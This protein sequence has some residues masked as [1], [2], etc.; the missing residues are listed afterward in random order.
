[1]MTVL[2]WDVHREVGQLTCL[3]IMELSMT[4]GSPLSCSGVS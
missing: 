1:M 2:N 4:Q 3:L